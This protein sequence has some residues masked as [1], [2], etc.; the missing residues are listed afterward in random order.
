M[1]QLGHSRAYPILA[2]ALFHVFFAYAH[3]PAIYDVLF[4]SELLHRITHIALLVLAII[5]WLPM[6][7]PATEVFPRL[8]QPAQMLYAFAQSI[9]GAL[10]GSLLTLSDKM[11]YKH[12]GTA[13]DQVGIS[14]V[15][16][17]QLGGLLMWVVGGTFWLVVLTIIFFI[18]A[19]REQ[20][21]AYG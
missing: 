17:Q 10:V 3:L 12:Y 19:D 2:F 15:S 4:G 7:S 5:T 1:R 8:S 11:L 14:P 21:R 20:D 18:W 9:P 16:D 13:A 6:L